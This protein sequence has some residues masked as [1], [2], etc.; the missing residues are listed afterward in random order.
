VPVGIL[1][2][3]GTGQFGQEFAQLGVLVR[4]PVGEQF[5]QP[6]APGR[7]QPVGGLVTGVGEDPWYFPRSRGGT[8]S[9]M[10]AWAR[11]IRPPP[12]IP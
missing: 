1:A 12:P 5:A 9:P 7:E 2:E 10:M 6:L 3:Q 8:T 4:R 11:T